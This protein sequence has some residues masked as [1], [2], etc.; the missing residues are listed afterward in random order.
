MRKL[1][2]RQAATFGDRNGG[3]EGGDVSVLS[4]P[5]D[6][7]SDLAAR[8]LV[9]VC[10]WNLNGVFWLAFDVDQAVSSLMLVASAYLVF[11][12]G[13]L[14]SLPLVLLIAALSAYLLLATIFIG[15]QSN[16]DQQGSLFISYSGT[17][18]LVWGM[19]GY[20]ANLPHEH[21]VQFLR[22]IRNALVIS[23]ASVWLS[24]ILYQYYVNLPLSA[25][26]RMG[27][28]FA[29]PNEAAYVSLLA[30]AF[31]LYVPYPRALLNIAAALLAAGA[32]VLTLSKTGM[33]TL[34]VVVAFFLM[35]RARG[36]SVFLLLL[37][38]LTILT[39]TQDLR[40]LLT[41]I[42]EQPFVEFSSFEKVRILA[43]ADILQGQINDETSTGRT[44]LWTLAF[45]RAWTNFPLGSGLGSGHYLTGGIFENDVWQGAHNV[46]LM[47]WVESGPLPPLLAFAAIATAVVRLFRGR[48]LPLELIC[49]LILGAQ[50]LAGHTAFSTRYHNLIL[51]VLLGLQATGARKTE[52]PGALRV[53]GS[54]ITRAPPGQAGVSADISTYPRSL[55]PVRGD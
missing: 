55:T 3:S 13:K 9:L 42:V 20:V 25:S 11:R 6:W 1:P 52:E 14:A 29:N 24:P 45:D 2:A 43:V 7:T 39:I 18:L 4:P 33:T 21:R 44:F 28:F 19:T 35:R 41:A 31:T 30:L 5:A 26:R 37:A 51:A 8:A 48:S 53:L 47:M 32:V 12:C 17:I 36:W 49:I 16:Q 38:T 50:M 10:A 40:W 46:F 54:P 22:F 23:A 15:P 34:V 27:G